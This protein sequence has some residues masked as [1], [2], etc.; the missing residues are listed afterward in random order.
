MYSSSFCCIWYRTSHHCRKNFIWT[1][2]CF[3]QIKRNKVLQML[4][5]AARTCP[6]K[7][8]C[9]CLTGFLSR[10]RSSY[11]RCS[12]TKGVLRNFA[13]FWRKHLRQSPFFNKVVYRSFIKRVTLSNNCR[14]NQRLFIFIICILNILIQ[15]TARQ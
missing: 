3:I 6:V 9:N 1:S 7:R 2:F 12:V 8:Y 13:K 5:A 15:E 11:R 10:F 14:N 4:E